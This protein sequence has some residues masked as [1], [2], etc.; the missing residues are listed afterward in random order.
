MKDNCDKCGAIFIE[1]NGD[2]WFLLLLID[3][4]FFIFPIIAMFYFNLNILYL[5]IFTFTLIVLFIIGTP[6]R[7]GLSLAFNYYFKKNK[8]HY[9]YY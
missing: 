5:I 3:R 6:I 8:K 4:A 2:N 7:L 9:K 1:K